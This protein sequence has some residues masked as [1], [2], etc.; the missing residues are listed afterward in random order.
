MFAEAGFS[1]HRLE[2]AA[3]NHFS[4][5]SKLVFPLPALNSYVEFSVTFTMG[6]SLHV[7]DFLLLS[8]CSLLTFLAL[9]LSVPSCSLHFVYFPLL[10][11]VPHLCSV[12]G[13]LFS[14]CLW[15]EFQAL[16]KFH[17]TELSSVETFLG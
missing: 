8:W 3:G 1:E 4:P 14:L 6:V 10:L 5:Q 11:T 7:L 17:K 9:D 12:L 13:K 16:T 2:N 15:P